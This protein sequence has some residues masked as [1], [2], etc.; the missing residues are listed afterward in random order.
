M[1]TLEKD[2]ISIS[3]KEYARFKAL[4]TLLEDRDFMQKMRQLFALIDDENKNWYMGDDFK[5]LTQH[6]FNQIWDNSPSTWDNV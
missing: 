5:D 1:T 4:Y 6:A 3:A 2:N